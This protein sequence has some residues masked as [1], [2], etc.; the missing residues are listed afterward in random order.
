MIGTSTTVGST[1]SIWICLASLRVWLRL[2]VF[3]FAV[4][5]SLSPHGAFILSNFTPCS[6]HNSQMEFLL[7]CEI[8]HY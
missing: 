7:L 8:T 2:R 5:S 1:H 4:F 3:C 6:A